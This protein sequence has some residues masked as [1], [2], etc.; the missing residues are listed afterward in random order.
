MFW[1][2]NCCIHFWSIRRQFLYFS[3]RQFHFEVWYHRNHLFEYY[4]I[5]STSFIWFRRP[6]WIQLEFFRHSCRGRLFCC[7]LAAAAIAKYGPCQLLVRGSG[8]KQC[9]VGKDFFCTA[10]QP[11]QPDRVDVRQRSGKR[12]MMVKAGWSSKFWIWNPV[13]QNLTSLS[14][15]TSINDSLQKKAFAFLNR[16]NWWWF[17]QVPSPSKIWTTP[18]HRKKVEFV[19]SSQEKNHHNSKPQWILKNPTHREPE[20]VRP[21]TQM[22]F[23]WVF[24]GM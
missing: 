7:F 6:S 22:V 19:R 10:I 12:L 17:R 4:T 24:E 3:R 16:Q 13:V 18:N 20:I 8:C 2:L 5:H 1:C 14:K 11:V 15:V 21:S 23:K 9:I